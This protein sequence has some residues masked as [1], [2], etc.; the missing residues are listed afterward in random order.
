MTLGRLHVGYTLGHTVRLSRC[1]AHT[2]PACTWSLSCPRVG[3][4]PQRTVTLSS[5]SRITSNSPREVQHV[6]RAS[7]TSR[8]LA[9]RSCD[10]SRC[11][12]SHAASKAS[13]ASCPARRCGGSASACSGCLH[14]KAN[15]SILACSQRCRLNHAVLFGDPETSRPP[16]LRT[17]RASRAA[18]LHAS[19]SGHAGLDPDGCVP[20]PAL[21]YFRNEAPS[22]RDHRIQG[23]VPLLPPI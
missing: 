5:A 4:R 11:A 21:E 23:Q 19:Q 6:C 10:H 7:E 15:P 3:E 2:S 16:N 13:T 9:C 8:T 18:L 20:D 22:G 12:S 1:P 17:G 14:P